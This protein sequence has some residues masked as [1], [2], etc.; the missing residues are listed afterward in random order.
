MMKQSSYQMIEVEKLFGAIKGVA[1]AIGK[2]FV[3]L[4]V[5]CSNKV[6]IGAF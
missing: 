2:P 4:M 1:D 3:F 6:K 5:G